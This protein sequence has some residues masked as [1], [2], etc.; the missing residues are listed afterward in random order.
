MGG[1]GRRDL[2]SRANST[3]DKNVLVFPSYPEVE[4]VSVNIQTRLL[5]LPSTGRGVADLWNSLNS[6]YQQ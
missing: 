2:F 4:F 5:D 1:K 6:K 3:P